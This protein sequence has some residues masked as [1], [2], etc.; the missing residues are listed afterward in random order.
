MTFEEARQLHN[1]DEISCE[2]DVGKVL[3][4]WVTTVDDDEE[5]VVIE[6]VF[7]K[8]GWGLVHHTDVD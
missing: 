3:D 8:A 4:A 7:K 2:G 1:G 6:A 5:I